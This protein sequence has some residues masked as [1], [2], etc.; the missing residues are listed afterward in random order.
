M[1]DHRILVLTRTCLHREDGSPW[2]PTKNSRIC[3]QHFINGE[4]SNDP[5]SPAYVPT[6]FPSVCG[7]TKHGTSKSYQ[8]LRA[9][10]QKVDSITDSQALEDVMVDCTSEEEKISVGSQTDP[11]DWR[12]QSDTPSLFLCCMQG[13]NAETQVASSVCIKVEQ[14]SPRTTPPHDV[15]CADVKQ[16]FTMPNSPLPLLSLVMESV[17]IKVEPRSPKTMLPPA[18]T[19]DDIK[20]EIEMPNSPVSSVFYDIVHLSWRVLDIKVEPASPATMLA[21]ERLDMIDKEPSESSA[22]QPC[23]V[24]VTPPT[25]STETSREVP[26]MESNLRIPGCTPATS[27]TQGK[28]LQLANLS[29]HEHT[30]KPKNFQCRPMLGDVR[31]QVVTAKDTC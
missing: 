31:E 27:A 5:R 7:R 26:S 20:E 24:V 9:R 17:D 10:E 16:E 4:R 29:G 15:T 1:R 3:S 18:M 11:C 21:T 30:H 6:I 14:S 2:E 19:Y 28:Q 23:S 13:C 25:C 22:L 8:R 12:A